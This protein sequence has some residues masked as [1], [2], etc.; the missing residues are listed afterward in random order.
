MVEASKVATSA[1]RRSRRRV[2]P[3]GRRIRSRQRGNP[4][5]HSASKLASRT[6][7]T[8]GLHMRTAKR[9][10]ALLAAFAALPLHAAISGSVMN[11]DGQPI[12]AAKISLFTPEGIAARRERLLSKT[13]Q[14]PPLA[15]ASSDANGVFRIEA[16][17]DKPIVELRV[18]APGYAPDSER[19]QSDDDVG[20]MVL[21]HAESKSGTVK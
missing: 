19:L 1:S 17:K 9:L 12:A 11:S 10:L 8:G 16:P 15:T 4:R 5:A 21:T 6:L 2:W 13:P 7:S 20:A 18:E 3:T 14:R